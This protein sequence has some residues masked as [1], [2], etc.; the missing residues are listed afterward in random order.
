VGKLAVPNLFVLHSEIMEAES[1]VIEVRGVCPVVGEVLEEAGGW[2]Y[3]RS[4]GLPQ[5]LKPC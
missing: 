4:S 3:L 2:G 1:W 5:R